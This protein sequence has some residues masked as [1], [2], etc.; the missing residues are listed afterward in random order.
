MN[1]YIYQKLNVWDCHPYQHLEEASERNQQSDSHTPYQLAAVLLFCFHPS[2]FRV[3]QQLQPQPQPGDQDT[4]SSPVKSAK[5][6]INWEN[7]EPYRTKN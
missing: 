7:C 3:N 6:C 5:L 1:H 2:F 4:A